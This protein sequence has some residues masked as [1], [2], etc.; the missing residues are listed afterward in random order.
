MTE[1]RYFKI[2]SNQCGK[3]ER[4]VWAADD[5][6]RRDRTQVCSIA[7]GYDASMWTADPDHQDRLRSALTGAGISYDENSYQQVRSQ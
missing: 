6:A 1:Q 2:A 5:A 3:A 4:A 7:I